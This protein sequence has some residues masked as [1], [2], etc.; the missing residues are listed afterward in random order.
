MSNTEWS[1]NLTSLAKT[2]EETNRRFKL[3]I[4]EWRDYLVYLSLLPEIIFRKYQ[5]IP[6]SLDEIRGSRNFDWNYATLAKWLDY[7]VPGDKPLDPDLF[8]TNRVEL[9]PRADLSKAVLDLAVELYPRREEL[10]VANSPTDIWFAWEVQLCNEALLRCGLITGKPVVISKDP[11]AKGI[12]DTVFF[13]ENAATLEPNYKNSTKEPAFTSLLIIAAVTAKESQSF[14][15]S[16]AYCKF[17]KKARAWSRAVRGGNSNYSFP[18]FENGQK[19]PSGRNARREARRV[20]SGFVTES[21]QK[22]S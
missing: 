8:F 13:L 7:L 10:Q 2:L 22:Q 16:D 15:Y 1:S 18:C 12:R 20:S 4:Q 17:Q 6:G 5:F 11:W 3:N 21:L 9:K 19:L 14:R